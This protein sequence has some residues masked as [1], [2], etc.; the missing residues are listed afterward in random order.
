MSTLSIK[1]RNLNSAAPKRGA[2][3]CRKQTALLAIAVEQHS[4]RSSI[5]KLFVRRQ[6]HATP[7]PIRDLSQLQRHGI[8]PERGGNGRLLRHG[9]KACVAAVSLIGRLTRSA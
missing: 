1:S 8:G 3:L 9:E 6:N 7:A 5:A 2:A 4:A